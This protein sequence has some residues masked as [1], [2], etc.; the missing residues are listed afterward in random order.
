[1]SVSGS[2][3][4]RRRVLAAFGLMILA[5]PVAACSQAAPVSPTAA[6]NPPP[7]TQ[8]ATKP[9]AAPAAQPTVSNAKVPLGIAVRADAQ[10]SWQAD[11]AKDFGKQ[12]P[13]VD[14]TVTQVQY[15]DM[16]KKQLAMLATG[17]MPDVIFSG[18]KWFSYSA[19]KGAFRALDD[20]VKQKDPG[21][22]DFFKA[23]ILSCQLDG[24]LFGLPYTMNPGNTNIVIYNKD[25]L[26]AKGVKEPDDNWTMDDFVAATSKATDKARKVYGTDLLPDSYYDLATWARTLG[27]DILSDDGKQFTLA[28]DPKTVDATRWIA[29]LRTKHHAAPGRADSQG[30]A[31]PAGQIALSCAATYTVQGMGKAVGNRF[32]W[33]AVLAP[34]GPSGLRGYEM[35]ASMYSLYSKTKH[36]PEAFDL[37]TSE[38]SVETARHAFFDQGLPPARPSLWNAP[39]AEKI[40]PIFGRVA[41]W[42]DDGRDKGPFPMPDNLRFSELQDKF[43]NLIPPVYYGDVDFNEGLKKVQDDC[44]QIVALP[45]G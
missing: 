27:G 5:T 6:T 44:Q 26:A 7:T 18:A 31:F 11:A 20:L 36:A 12:H 8:Q 21:M 16:A 13:N 17:T 35:F 23:S 4:S 1:M 39:E 28:T 41:K 15:A 40:S 30:I 29:E 42:L 32:K 38:V 22:G 19:Y 45:R 3:L 14:L 33:D 25:L 10:F 9:T 24:K 2:T 34:V 43:Q 37:L